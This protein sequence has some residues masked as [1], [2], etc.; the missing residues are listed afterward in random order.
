VTDCLDGQVLRVIC[1]ERKHVWVPFIMTLPT[2]ITEAPESLLMER[3]ANSDFIFLTEAG[4]SPGWPDD[5]QMRALLPRTQAWCAANLQRVERFS[6]FG[7][8][9]VLYR[10]P[11]PSEVK[12]ES[13]SR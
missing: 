9:M 7:K 5:R 12:A 4:P 8:Q 2:G 3:L 6:I 13:K 1:Y 11:P 10:R